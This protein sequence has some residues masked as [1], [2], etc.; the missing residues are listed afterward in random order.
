MRCRKRWLRKRSDE[1][2]SL[3]RITHITSDTD[4]FFFVFILILIILVL[5]RNLHDAPLKPATP[6]REVGELE[7]R[8]R[9]RHR[10]LLT[11]NSGLIRHYVY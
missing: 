9:A 3:V 11:D 8:R 6:R 5:Y 7:L 1:P 10:H 4:N 2:S